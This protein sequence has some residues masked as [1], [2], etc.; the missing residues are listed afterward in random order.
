MNFEAE[1]EL[2]LSERAA[3]KVFQAILGTITMKVD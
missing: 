2:L 1:D 3:Q